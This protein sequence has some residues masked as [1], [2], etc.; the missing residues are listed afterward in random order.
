MNPT[1]P[2]SALT[3][4]GATQQLNTA[5]IARFR[6]VGILGGMGP[7]ATVDLVQKIIAATLASSDQEHVPMI[8]WN[9]PQIPDRSLFL[10]G[11][12]PSPAGAMCNAACS[13]A[14]AGAEAIAIACNTAHFWADE[15]A[16]AANLP[17]IHIV[18]A[19][20][21]EVF[22]ER[23]YAQQTAQP[24]PRNIML[25][26]TDA[27]QSLGV[28]AKRAAQHNITLLSPSRADQQVITDVISLV[29]AGQTE[30]GRALILPM[31]TTQLQHG[32]DRFLLGC[33]EMPL[34]VGGTQFEAKSIDATLALAAAIVQFSAG[35][36]AEMAYPRVNSS[37]N[38]ERNNAFGDQVA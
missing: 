23:Q 34:V 18:D 32:V 16:Q 33:T 20:L 26:S 24:S 27:T 29:K 5:P 36:L 7:A 21:A 11:R 37:N 8:V 2:P 12:G 3:T 28:Y 6:M 35:T 25:L 9:V 15:I 1:T 10:D 4:Q 19:A 31:L 38:N 22:L 30:K 13:L 14:R 17:V